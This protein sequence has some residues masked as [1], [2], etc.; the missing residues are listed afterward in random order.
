[1]LDNPLYVKLYVDRNAQLH[2]GK[3]NKVKMK[4]KTQGMI[5]IHFKRFLMRGAD[6]FDK[7]QGVNRHPWK[8][9]R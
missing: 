8:L 6:L 3:S 5:L 7:K 1:M 9:Q 2:R 4:I